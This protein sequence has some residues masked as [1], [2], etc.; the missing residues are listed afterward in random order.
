MKINNE[1]FKSVERA[2][3][4]ILV[5]TKYFDAQKTN[6]ILKK[7]CLQKSFLACGENRIEDLKKKNLS[8]E[9]VHF[10]GK[11]RSKNIADIFQFCSVIHSL[12]SVKHAQTLNKLAETA[13]EKFPVFLQLN[14]AQEPQ[15][16]G[17][18]S[19]D[20]PTFLSEILVLENLDILGISALGL[21]EFTLQGKQNEFSLL[22]KIRDEFLPNKKISAGTSRDFEIALAQK[23]EVVRIGRALFD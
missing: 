7:V 12:E 6:E 16:S 22:Q 5:V 10:I 2:N 15:K 19:N 17:I 1:I 4:Q 18:L 20:F 11:I 14:I 23:I 21:G 8:R 3:S 13:N 9:N